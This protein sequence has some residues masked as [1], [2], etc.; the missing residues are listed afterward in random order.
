VE[1]YAPWCGHCKNLAPIWAA[2]ATE[3]K[4]KVKLGAVDATV[5]QSL[6]GQYDIKG[7]PTI[8][9]FPGGKKDPN[10]VEDYNGD[11]SK[12]G[13]VTWAL[14]K[15]A[16]SVPPPEIKEV[17]LPDFRYHGKIIFI[18]FTSLFHTKNILFLCFLSRFFF[19]IEE[20]VN[21]K[22]NCIILF[23]ECLLTRLPHLICIRLV[24]CVQVSSHLKYIRL[25]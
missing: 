22:R 21:F 19:L 1:F 17:L 6:A 9:Y 4:G 7:Y 2:A 10:S 20:M 8:K 5:H 24:P 25:I 12:D 11:R 3:L 16:E 18:F 23:R 14:N 13:I 15:V